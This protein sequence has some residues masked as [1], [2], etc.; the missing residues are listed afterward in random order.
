VATEVALATARLLRHRL[1]DHDVWLPVDGE[2]M[3]PTIAPPAEVRVIAR[4]RPWPGEV[5]AFVG[6]DGSI[7]VHRFERRLRAGLVFHG[8]ALVPTDPVTAPDVLVGRVVA[9]RDGRGERVLGTV[10]QLRGGARYLLRRA[11]RGVE[12]VARWAVSLISRAA[13]PG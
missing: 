2:S 3:Q 9:V 8:D 6:P 11:R 13:R 4:R 12:A 7:V 10:D 1:L 5:W